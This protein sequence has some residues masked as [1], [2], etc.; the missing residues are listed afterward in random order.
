MNLPRRSTRPDAAAPRLD[1]LAVLAAFT[2]LCVLALAGA[3]PARAQLS[4]LGGQFQVNSYTTGIQYH[5]AV[6][7]DSAGNFVIVWTSFGSTG[8]DSSNASVQ[9]RRWAA[10]GSPLGA[11]FQVNTYTTSTQRFPAL[12]AASDGAF[13]V[14]WSSL[15][16]SG[17]DTSDVSVQA[18]RYLSNGIATGAQAQVNSFT[19]LEQEFPA[20]A[21]DGLG[22]Y[23]VAWESIGSSGTDTSGTSIQ[24]QRFAANGAALGA[25]F[26]VN[27]YTTGGQLNPQVAVDGSGN[28]VVVWNSYG[29]VGTDG[30]SASI[31]G[32]FYAA[33]GA[34]LGGQF[35]VN[36]FTTS[37]QRYPAAA[38]DDAGNFIVAWD[39]F[40]SSATDTSSFS[41]QAQRYAADGAALGGQFQVNTYTTNAQRYPSVAADDAGNF[42]VVWQSVGSSGTDSDDSSIHGRRFA[43]SG[44]PVGGEAQVN[45]FTTGIQELPVVASAGAGDFVVV[46]KSVGSFGTDSS[47]SSIQAQRFGCVFCDGFEGGDTDRW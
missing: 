26:Q 11:A 8:T 30:D 41:I 19:T 3:A 28:F 4:P 23:V 17:T 40:G 37:G 27:T 2:V 7:A 18:Q 44:V 5:P 13:V 9:T 15:G 6:A 29:S 31:Q 38:A 46:W 25:Q 32:R 10:D 16:S 1:R 43:A 21:A 22:N 14:V 35:Q 34:A 33:N 47:Y 20:V 36:S 42:V 39:S 45:S 12:A 24:A